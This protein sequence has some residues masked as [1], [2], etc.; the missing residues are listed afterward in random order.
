MRSFGGTEGVG[1]SRRRLEKGKKGRALVA[2]QEKRASGGRL[3]RGDLFNKERR[4]Q[5]EGKSTTKP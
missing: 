5:G 4:V 3:I 2:G 1:S